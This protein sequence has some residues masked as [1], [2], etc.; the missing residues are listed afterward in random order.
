M[1][2]PTT[3]LDYHDQIKMMTL[4]RALNEVGHTIIIITH[5][6]W[7]AAEYARRVIVMEAG[8]IVKDGSPRNLFADGAVLQ[9]TRLKPPKITQLG[10]RLGIP[11]LSV[12]EFVALL[13]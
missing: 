11:V 2:E 10:N 13:T 3:G 4:L 6:I 12:D 5:S 8:Q 7:L 1:D 9:Q